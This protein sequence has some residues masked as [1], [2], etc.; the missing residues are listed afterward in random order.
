L[1]YY[2][3]LCLPP[4]APTEPNKVAKT[5]NGII[6][7]AMARRDCRRDAALEALPSNAWD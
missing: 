2:C 1:L 6:D 3:S 7:A 5:K 4:F